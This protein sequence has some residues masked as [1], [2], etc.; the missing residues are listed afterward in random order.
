MLKQIG[1]CAIWGSP[2]ADDAN[3]PFFA[4]QNSGTVE[5][6]G[7]GVNELKSISNELASAI[8]DGL[9]FYEQVDGP[10]AHFPSCQS[11][12][13]AFMPLVKKFL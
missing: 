8:N 4:V 12:Y 7:N 11:R 3:G 5:G 1:M 6:S 10:F 13:F 2:L 9:Y